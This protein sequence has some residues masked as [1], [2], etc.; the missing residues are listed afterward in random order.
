MTRLSDHMAH[1]PSFAP[2][3]LLR[4]EL[5]FGPAEFLA[6]CPRD[7]PFLWLTSGHRGRHSALLGERWRLETFETNWRW[8]SQGR[9]QD[10]SREPQDLP[11]VMDQLHKYWLSQQSPEVLCG[12][13]LAYEAGWDQEER[14][15]KKDPL[16]VPLALLFCPLQL[17]IFD[18]SGA[19]SLRDQHQASL[20]MDTPNSFK[21]QFAVGST[22]RARQTPEDYLNQAHRVIDH[23]R[24]G[25]SFQVN[26]SQEFY[27]EEKPEVFSWAQHALATQPSA[28]GA[29]LNQLDFSIL[30]LSPERLLRQNEARHL[31]TRPIAGTL[32]RRQNLIEDD[33]VAFRN[34]PKEC[35]EHNML[36]D[37][38]RNDLGKVCRASSVAVEE[39]LTVETLPHVHHLVSQVGGDLE[40]GV[41]PGSALFAAFPGGTITGCPKLETMHILDELEREERGPYTGSLGYLA[42]DHFDTNILI[43]S[44]LI[45]HSGVRMRFGGGIVW[46]SEPRKEFLETLAKARGLLRSLLEGGAQLDSRYRPFR[47]LF[48]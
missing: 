2:H 39:Y 27:T 6:R 36:I 44:A 37:L 9:V 23:I 1:W 42:R 30:S 18:E 10:Y 16:S 3:G 4:E 34:N 11:K 31:I 19:W 8:S 12:L 40:D 21:A 38:E 47:Q 22:I 28:F 5:P 13:F 25:N 35:A 14:K 17:L 46:D 41:G 32:P 48:L 20:L 24:A 15:V 29:F 33:L 26:L 45:D 7:I 43:R